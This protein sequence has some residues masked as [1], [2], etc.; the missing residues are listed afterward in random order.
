MSILADRSDTLTSFEN[1][2]RQLLGYVLG[3]AACALIVMVAPKDLGGGLF[4]PWSLPPSS[5]SAW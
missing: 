4:S 3:G 1:A 2:R 5:F